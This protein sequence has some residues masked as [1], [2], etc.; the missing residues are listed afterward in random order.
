MLTIEKFYFNPDEFEISAGASKSEWHLDFV[1]DHVNIKIS[2]QSRSHFEALLQRI[3]DI[4][5]TLL[6]G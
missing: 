6:V 2:V 5:K 4:G 3:Q 1:D